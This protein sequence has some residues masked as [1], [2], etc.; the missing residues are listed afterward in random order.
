MKKT[1]FSFL[2]FLAVGVCLSA[3]N[4]YLLPIEGDKVVFSIVENPRIT[5]G[6]GTMTIHGTTFEL[7]E[8]QTLSFVRNPATNL[9]AV[10]PHDK[11]VVFPNP[12][13]DQLSIIV[14]DPQG[15][16][17][18]IFDLNGRLLKAGNL[19]STV[20]TINVQG[21]RIGT[22]VLHIDRNGQPIQSLQ[23]VKQ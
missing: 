12:V 15:M 19:N 9:V 18:R 16:T 21:L 1:L 23:I 7:A 8:V 2:L 10:N 14:D 6:N 13:R 5:F 3:R 4:L 17:Y 20:T 22:Y 11:I